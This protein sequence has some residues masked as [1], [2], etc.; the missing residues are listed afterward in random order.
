MTIVTPIWE[1]TLSPVR[2]AFLKRSI[3]ESR[4]S[5]HWFIAP[6]TLDM[7]WYERAFPHSR[8]HHFPDRYFSSPQAYSRLLTDPPFYRCWDDREF[9]TICQTDAVLIKDP[10][11]VNM[12]EID[13]LGAP[14]CPPVRYLKMGKR[15]YVTSDFGHPGESAIVRTLGKRIYVGNGGLSIRRITAH[16]NVCEQ[17]PASIRAKYLNAINED[18][19]L[20]S[21]G[22]SLGLCIADKQFAESVFLESQ[23][24]EYNT[25]PDVTGFHALERWNAEL[26]SQVVGQ[27]NP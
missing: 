13:Y 2:E 9:V 5:P 21:I 19:L 15:L 14:W 10:A 3:S 23:V 25:L 11:H 8:T 24:K 12:D 16:I 1:A 7:S 22:P 20:C 6:E 18:A 27:V 26:V 17:L 4:N